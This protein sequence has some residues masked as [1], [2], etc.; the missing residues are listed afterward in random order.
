[1]GKHIKT[2]MDYDIINQLAREVAR[3][4]PEN[5][6]LEKFASMDNYEGGELRKSIAD[7]VPSKEFGIL[8]TDCRG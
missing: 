8:C 7:V 2:K 3:L 1:V 5:L 4:D 6:V